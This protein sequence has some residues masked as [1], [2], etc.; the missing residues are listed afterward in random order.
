MK[1]VFLLCV[2][3]AF[4]MAFAHEAHAGD[5][6]YTKGPY[7]RKHVPICVDKVSNVPYT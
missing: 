6:A 5:N 3:L 1:I 4:I 2:L 7:K